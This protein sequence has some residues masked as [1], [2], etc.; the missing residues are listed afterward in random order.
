[1]HDICS[2]PVAQANRPIW[3]ASNVP[4]QLP[5]LKQAMKPLHQLSKQPILP[6]RKTDEEPKTGPQRFQ[7]RPMEPLHQFYPWPPQYLENDIEQRARSNRVTS[8][9]RDIKLTN[10]NDVLFYGSIGIG[11][12]EQRF[13]VTFSTASPTT[14]VPSIHSKPKD[15]ELTTYNNQTSSTYIPN[16]VGFQASYG[17]GEVAGYRSQDNLNIAG[18]TARNQIFGEAIVA[19]DFFRGTPNQG[20]LGLGFSDAEPTV[21]DNLAD[22]G[23]LPAAVFSFYLS[24]HNSGDP[25]P[26]LT[27]GGTNPAYYVGDFTFADLTVPDSWQF[28]MDRVQLS[29]GTG[30]F[31]GWGCQA[32]VDSSTPLIIGPKEE[33]DVL[34]RKLGG[35]P[36]PGD[37]TMYE[38]DCSEVDNLP[39]VEFIV[40]GKKLSLTNKDYVVTASESG[41][42][43][44]YSGIM[45]SSWKQNESPV[46]ILGLSF[47][48][49]YYT[50]F[51]KENY[52]IGFAKALTHRY[53]LLNK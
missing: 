44:C 47:M 49:V 40:N 26:V 51:D 45:G 8:K 31:N 33:V 12:P 6:I 7:D 52:R 48:K 20:V 13:N 42:T 53:A 43:V 5:P 34:N 23:L 16:G 38:L 25:D 17:E 46:W 2:I 22:Q 36:F 11:T 29:S 1:M 50:Q 10:L 24:K 4:R 28:K 27:L 14:W 15:S 21:F 9:P 37:P 19:S 41:R 32:V 18:L 35:T 39:D 3:R 30:I